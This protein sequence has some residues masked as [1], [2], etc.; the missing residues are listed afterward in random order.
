MITVSFS[1]CE[2][3]PLPHKGP[4]REEKTPDPPQT[5]LIFQTKVNTR[6][7]KSTH[8]SYQTQPQNPL[9]PGSYTLISGFCFLFVPTHNS[10]CSFT[11]RSFIE[12][13][14]CLCKV[15]LLLGLNFAKNTLT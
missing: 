8:P 12:S 13:A 3:L 6:P 5:A 15:C 14:C 11:H 7:S 10:L 1:C 4:E 2:P 9:Q